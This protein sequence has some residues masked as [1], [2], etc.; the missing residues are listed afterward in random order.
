[1][2]AIAWLYLI[3][4]FQG[5]GL[6]LR[7]AVGAPTWVGPLVVGVV[8]LANIGSGGMRSITFVQAFQYWLKL[9]A[10]LLPAAIL[11]AVWAGDGAPG[12]RE[13]GRRRMS[14]PS[15]RA[16]WPATAAVAAST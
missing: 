1:M 11:L 8:V 14:R 6:T 2:V 13:R 7:S 12:G 9:T 15:G 4:Q 3:P 10:L 16:R 5:A